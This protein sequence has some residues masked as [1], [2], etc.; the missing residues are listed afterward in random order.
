M[1]APSAV[2]ENLARLREISALGDPASIASRFEEIR[3]LAP[4]AL[5]SAESE[6]QRVEVLEIF[7]RMKVEMTRPT[8]LTGP[9]GVRDP[10]VAKVEATF[11]ELLEREYRRMLG[12]EFYIG[13]NVSAE[14]WNKVTLREV[15][16]G[17]MAPDDSFRKHAETAV[18]APHMSTAELVEQL[19]NKNKPAPKPEP[20]WRRIVETYGGLVITL[21]FYLGIPW[22]CYRLNDRSWATFWLALGV[23][24]VTRLIFAAVK[25]LSGEFTHRMVRGRRINQVLAFLKEN[26]FPDPNEKAFTF[27]RSYY[28][29]VN[30]VAIGELFPDGVRALAQKEQTYIESIEPYQDLI[31]R[32]RF[33]G[34][35]DEAMNRFRAESAGS[36]K[37]GAT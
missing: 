15:A 27:C 34:P 8:S 9:D 36:V 6:E 13:E 31:A 29:Y 24:I 10:S 12:Q 1:S 22:A 5:Q 30:A 16:A 25:W 7:H 37:R 17:R 33:H 11:A 26:R 14:L 32:I 19:R 2:D 18:L 4:L 21:S 3:S 35:L 28:S 23:L 20:Q